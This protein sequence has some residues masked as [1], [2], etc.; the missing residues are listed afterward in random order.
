MT[1]SGDRW[2]SERTECLGY[3]D[4]SR[5]A[6]DASKRLRYVQNPGSRWLVRGRH[7]AI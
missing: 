5:P 3:L 2:G 7:L 4:G 1:V 6:G